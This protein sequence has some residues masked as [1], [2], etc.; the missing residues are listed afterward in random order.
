MNVQCAKCGMPM[1]PGW[2]FCPRCAA[3]PAMQPVEPQEHEHH[4]ARAAFGGLVYGLITAPI[5]VIL[6]IMICLT[7]WGMFLGLPVIVM[8]IL[9]PVAGPLFGMNEHA[10]KC[11]VCGTRV[12]TVADG[13]EHA[14]PMCSGEFAVSEHHIVK[15]Y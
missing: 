12:V 4:R 13:K 11:P 7:G 5:L 10:A 14:C 2:K 3:E 9:A 15:A 6:G 1:V 8:G